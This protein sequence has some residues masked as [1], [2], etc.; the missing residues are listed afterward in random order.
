[1]VEGETKIKGLARGNAATKR[2]PADYEGIGFSDIN[3]GTRATN[4]RVHIRHLT[5]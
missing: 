5:G 4:T 1:M 3:P 2:N